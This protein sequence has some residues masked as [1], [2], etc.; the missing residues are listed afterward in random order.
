MGASLQQLGTE[1]GLAVVDVP[2]EAVDTT[3]AAFPMHRQRRLG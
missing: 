2:V 1:P 3:R